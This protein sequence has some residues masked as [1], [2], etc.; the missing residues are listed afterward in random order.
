MGNSPR[1]RP[2]ARL[3]GVLAIIVPPIDPVVNAF[4]GSVSRPGN[5]PSLDS[6]LPSFGLGA[7]VPY[8]CDMREAHMGDGD[9]IRNC[10]ISNARHI[11]V[12]VRIR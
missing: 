6:P 5:G 7:G 12:G 1:R 3:D 8:G 4:S 9:P 2:G 10:L 11:G